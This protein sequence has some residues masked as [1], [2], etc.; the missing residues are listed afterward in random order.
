MK[1]VVAFLRGSKIC[2]LA[3][4]GVHRRIVKY[5]RVKYSLGIGVWLHV[6]AFKYVDKIVI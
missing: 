1:T 5:R 6:L 4:W 2:A 3:S